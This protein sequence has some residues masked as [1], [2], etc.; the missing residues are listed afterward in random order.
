MN[1]FEEAKKVA[2]N[3]DFSVQQYKYR[4]FTGSENEIIKEVFSISFMINPDADFE[5]TRE[6][7]NPLDALHEFGNLIAA[8]DLKIEPRDPEDY[9][10]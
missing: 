7:I 10:F 8:Q 2:G 9:I 5:R 6:Y 3:R 4:Y 1:L